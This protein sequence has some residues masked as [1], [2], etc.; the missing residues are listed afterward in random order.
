ML[1]SWTLP[2]AELSALLV[3]VHSPLTSISLQDL[4]R[5]CKASCSEHYCVPCLGGT[6]FL[7]SQVGSGG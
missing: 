5:A 7:G 2:P 4:A 6:I 3:Q 1:L